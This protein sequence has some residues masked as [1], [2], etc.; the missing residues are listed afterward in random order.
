MAFSP[1]V[2]FAAF[3]LLA[4]LVASCA[5]PSAPVSGPT[6]LP[7]ETPASRPELATEPTRPLLTGPKFEP[8]PDREYLENSIGMKLVRVPAGKFMMGSPVDEAERRDDEMPHEVEITKPFWL[9][10]FEVTQEEFE[11]VMGSNP[12]HF[13]PRGGGN[14]KV[15]EFDTRRFPVENVSWDEA[16]AFCRK[17]SEREAE[18]KAGRSYLLPSEA[19][20]EYACR[21]GAEKYSV[22]SFANILSSD[23]ANFDGTQPYPEDRPQGPSLKRTTFVG[24]Y[25]PNAF[26]LFDMHGNVSE[27]VTDGYGEYYEKPA[28]DPV[29]PTNATKI[30]RGGNWYAPGQACRSAARWK[31]IPGETFLRHGIGFRVVCVVQLEP[32]K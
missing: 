26:G 19:Q 29:A 24:S 3:A 11:T 27:W 15:R 23:R 9:G 25:K 16:Q 32:P 20:W 21:A 31:R 18:K 2:R 22:F 7:G 1:P 30:A 12:S 4:V 6:G 10:V 28:K 14:Y 5:P 13:A 17:L 8:L